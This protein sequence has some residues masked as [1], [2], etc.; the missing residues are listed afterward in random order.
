MPWSGKVSAILTNFFPGQQAG[1]SIADVLFGKVNP[2]GKLPITFPNKVKCRKR[3]AEYGFDDS[4][5]VCVDLDLKILLFSPLSPLFSSSPL[6]LSSS[7]LILPCLVFSSLL[8][9][10]RTSKISARPS[11]R[12]YPTPRTP[13]MPTTQRSLRW[14]TATTTPTRSRY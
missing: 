14:A 5:G 11:G 9:C 4:G 13:P 3:I 6:L 1:N 8:E 12:V 7:S 2:S 10:R